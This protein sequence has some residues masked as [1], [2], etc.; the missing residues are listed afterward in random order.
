[1]SELRKIVAA[2]PPLLTATVTGPTTILVQWLQIFNASSYNLYRDGVLIFS[3]SVL[4]YTDTGLATGT[5]YTYTIASVNNRAGEGRPSAPVTGMT[6]VVSSTRVWAPGHYLDTGSGT[7]RAGAIKPGL[8]A[9]VVRKPWNSLEPVDHKYSMT[10]VGTLLDLCAGYKIHLFVMIETKSFNSTQYAPP[11]LTALST[12]YHNSLG[13]GGFVMWRHNPVVNLA[14]KPLV[15]AVGDYVA[16]H[17]NKAWFAGIATQETGA[18]FAPGDPGG[19]PAYLPADYIDA[20]CLESDY[21]TQGCPT[22]RGMHYV[23]Q[24]P[25]NGNGSLLPKYY[26]KVRANG[27]LYGFPDLTMGNNG[28]HDNVYPWVLNA[29]NAG[30]ATFASVQNAEYT[31]KAPADNRTMANLHKYATAQIADDFGDKQN[32]AD[33]MVWTDHQTG[34]H[35][36]DS[37]AVTVIQANPPPFGTVTLS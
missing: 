11:R 32:H 21:I 6:P 19:D 15:K 30:G 22:G 1:M 8:A 5:L 13:A 31:P 10:A 12:H 28:I 18:Q 23:N 7:I 4:T 37:E 14:F 3:G 2:I 36:Y 29:H 25:N 9:V 17:K 35:N 33:V 20:L 26:N 27:G 24:I 34:A 16:T